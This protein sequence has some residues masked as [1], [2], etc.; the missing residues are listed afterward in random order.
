MNNLK[1]LPV[2]K[3]AY[4]LQK[5]NMV[6]NN[7]QSQ[8]N[9]TYHNGCCTHNG[10]NIDKVLQT[11]EDFGDN[12]FL[13][14][15]N[16]PLRPDAFDLSDE[17]K[18]AKISEHFYE[19]MHIMGLDMTDD[20]LR[21][22]PHRV[23][24][25]YIKEIYSGLN[26]DNKPQMRTFENKYQYNEMLIEKDITFYST[27]E[28]HFVPIYGKAHVAYIPNENVVGL[29]KLNRMVQYCA[30]RPQVQERLTVQIAEELKKALQTKDVAVIIEADHMCVASR[31]VQD[32]NSNTITTQYH[33]KFKNEKTREEFLKHIY[34]K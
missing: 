12:H 28:H 16:T 21:G 5:L 29:S 2:H 17:E 30:R 32:V 1:V 4:Y 27:C 22:T 33:G 14:S 26:P 13:S 3:I 7:G 15:V 11:Y 19:I 20:S 23:A 10:E 6:E 24:K 9:N 8:N 34:N 18:I 25:M 31:G